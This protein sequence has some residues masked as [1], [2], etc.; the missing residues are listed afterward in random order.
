MEET[1]PLLE[2]FRA[3]SAIPR[4]SSTSQPNPTMM[5]A[6]A[7]PSPRCAPSDRLI[8]AWA[9]KPRM[10]PGM[11]GKKSSPAHEQ[12]SEAMASPFVFGAIAAPY[13]GYCPYPYCG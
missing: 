13:A 11:A 7:S 2:E 6:T 12:I 3:P 9:T 8:C 10:M 5:P 4:A 1:M